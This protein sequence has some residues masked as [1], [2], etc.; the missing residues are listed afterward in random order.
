VGRAGGRGPIVHVSLRQTL[1]LIRVGLPAL[2]AEMELALH[3]IV[4]VGYDESRHLSASFRENLGTASPPLHPQPMT[5]VEAVVHEFSHNK[6]NA[7]F[8]IDLVLHNAFDPLFA[9]PVRPDPRPLHGVLLA[10]HAFLAVESLYRALR[11]LNHPVCKGPGFETRLDSIA[12]GNR[13][14]LQTLENAEPT[15]AGARLLAELRALGS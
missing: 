15:D 10:V 8:E 2:Y 1:A 5:M 3:Q 7:L 12:A 13:A 6:L 4:P 9:S 11:K 14:G